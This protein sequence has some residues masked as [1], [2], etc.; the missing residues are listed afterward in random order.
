MPALSL[1]LGVYALLL[2]LT[3]SGPSAD[4]PKPVMRP[5][6]EAESDFAI[7]REDWGRGSSGESEIIFAAW[8]DGFIVWSGDG[9]RGGPPY[10]AGRVDPKIV[11]LDTMREHG[12]RGQAGYESRQALVARTGGHRYPSPLTSCKA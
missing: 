6:S 8:P 1:W 9:L 7:H 11:R 2:D 4:E 10:R 12:G 3:T 5:I